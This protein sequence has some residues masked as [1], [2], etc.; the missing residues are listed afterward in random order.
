[1][2][3]ISLQTME[4]V[5]NC[6][7][8]VNQIMSKITLYI[9]FKQKILRGIDEILSIV[10]YYFKSNYLISLHKYLMFISFKLQLFL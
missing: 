9:F 3:E 5:N 2:L 6:L 7:I 1:M 10:N 4:N 8:M